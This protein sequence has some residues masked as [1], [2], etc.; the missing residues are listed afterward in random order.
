MKKSGERHILLVILAVVFVLLIGASVI[1]AARIAGEAMEKYA[2]ETTGASQTT[3]PGVTTLPSD[4]TAPATAPTEAGEKYL[5]V[6]DAGHQRKGNY[7]TEPIG[8]G[9]S[10]TKAKVT[11][12]T[13][14]RFTGLEEYV[15]NLQVS[16]LLRDIL[17]ERGYEVVMVRT[18]HDVDISNSQR[19]AV[20][21]ELD[22]DAFIR[23]HANGSDDPNV[24]GMMTICQTPDNPYNGSLYGNCRLLSE[25]V[26]EEMVASTGGKRQYVWETDTMSG[27]NWCAVPV[28]IVEMGYMSNEAEDRLMATAEYQRKLAEGIANG[29]DRYFAAISG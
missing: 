21:N 14:G 8:P 2:P 24:S 16:L 11:S 10:E 20:A 29:I 15:L 9:A 7:D 1:A 25:L 26:L 19:A 12:G 4:T 27:I 22:A 3:L 13:Q 6:I 18:T 28:T 5:V 23:I 17:L